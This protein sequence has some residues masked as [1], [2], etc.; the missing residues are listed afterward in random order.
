M[1]KIAY[2]LSAIAAGVFS[3]AHAD[4][5]VSGSGKFGY[6]SAG[7]ATKT[8][9]WGGV[10]FALSTTTAGGMTI[11]SSAGL[12]S[13]TE[14]DAANGVSGMTSLTFATGGTSITLGEDVTLAT[15]GG[16]GGVA[17]DFVDIGHHTIAAN[18]QTTDSDNDGAGISVSTTMGDAAVTFGYVYDL[19]LGTGGQGE[20]NA[21][22]RAQGINISMPM[23]ALTA[24]ASYVGY[25]NGNINDTLVGVGVSYSLGGGTLSVGYQSSTGAVKANET[26]AKYSMSLDA[27]TTIAIGYLQSDEGSTSNSVTEVALSRSLGGGASVWAETKNSSGSGASGGEASTFALGTSV[28]F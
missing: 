21:A 16:F 15:A 20:T 11:S 4:V 26:S 9:N 24:A 1:K 18:P 23:G 10:S 5:S 6:S 8:N 25:Q 22:D 12:S 3:T 28:A 2:L 17:S 19:T 14:G 27:D 13:D 7:S